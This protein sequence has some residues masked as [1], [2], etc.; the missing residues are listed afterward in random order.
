MDYQGNRDNSPSLLSAPGTWY[1][2]LV[3]PMW[4]QTPFPCCWTLQCA[5]WPQT[6]LSLIVS[7][8]VL[9]PQ[10]WTTTCPEVAAMRAKSS[11]LLD[12]QH[13]EGRLLLG[14]I[15]TG[16]FRP[17]VPQSFK[18][19]VFETMHSIAAHP[20]T[21]ASKCLILARFVWKCAAAYVAAMARAY[22]TCQEGTVR[23]TGTSTCRPS[24]SLCHPDDSA[25]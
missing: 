2:Y 5:T 7:V 3:S 12:T 24:T 13:V 1:M 14:D 20:G 23:S 22:L 6:S 17:V 8:P 15:S 25:S 11:L 21:Q 18:Q 19:Q 10:F 4:W 16:T 9:L